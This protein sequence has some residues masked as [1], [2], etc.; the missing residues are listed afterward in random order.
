MS[1]RLFRYIL[2]I[3]VLVFSWDACDRN[4][5]S[6]NAS[7]LRIKLT[8]AAAEVIKEFHV[9]IREISVYLV[10]TA[11]REGEWLALKFSGKTYDI[12]KLRNGKMAQM[13]DQYVPAGTE[14]QR[15]KLTLGNRNHL[16]TN[17]DSL[18]PL[19]IPS[20]LQ[21][22]VL[23]D[24]M[25]MELRLNT[26][27]SM[28]IDLN[29]ALSVRKKENGEYFLYPAA[30]AFPEIYGGK[31]HGYV[32]PLEANPYIKLIQKPDTLFASPEREKPDDQM[33]M[34]RFIGLKAGEWEVHL[35]PDPESGYRDT[36]ILCTVEEGKTAEVT[37]KPVRLKRIAGE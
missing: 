1:R 16:K 32:A 34:F 15:I 37:P 19:H 25:K 18:I 13:V 10:D 26:I 5:P 20:E 33:A 23:I 24:A 9:D 7:R 8:D 11:S 22:G 36:V 2:L 12:L 6:V 14:L 3:A 35:M 4:D 30:R 28:V 17:T 29:A 21:D 31:L 27:S